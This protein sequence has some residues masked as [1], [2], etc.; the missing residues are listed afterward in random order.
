MRLQGRAQIR[1]R[2]GLTQMTLAKLV[3]ISQTRL[4]CWENHE[5]ELSQEEVARVANVLHKRVIKPLCFNGASEL[6]RALA[7]D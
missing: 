3:G 5:G 7:A 6:A 4:S 1:K 2:A